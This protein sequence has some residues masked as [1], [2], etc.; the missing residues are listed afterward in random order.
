MQT[1]VEQLHVLAGIAEPRNVSVQTFA[2]IQSEMLKKTGAV[3]FCL[4][5]CCSFICQQASE[6]YIARKGQT[7]SADFLWVV[8]ALNIPPLLTCETLGLF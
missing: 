5:G 8:K 4:A 7:C 3:H 6:E 1:S 2:A